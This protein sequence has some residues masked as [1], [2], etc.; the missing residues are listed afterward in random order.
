LGGIFDLGCLD[1]F[2]SG[3]VDSMKMDKEY[4]IARMYY[5]YDL[6]QYISEQEP[7][8]IDLT[9]WH[10]NTDALTQMIALIEEDKV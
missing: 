7:R 6:M 1:C 2:I 8:L 10:T 3:R 4:R 5:L 9:D